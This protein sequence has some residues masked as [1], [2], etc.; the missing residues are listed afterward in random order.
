MNRPI[1]R[2]LVYDAQ[3]ENWIDY[4]DHLE[5]ENKDLKAFIASL[6]IGQYNHKE[7]TT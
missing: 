6:D 5:Q 7:E 2:C 3:M 4:A 1:E